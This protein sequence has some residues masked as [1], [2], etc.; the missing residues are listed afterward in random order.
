MAVYQK[1]QFHNNPKMQPISFLVP[2]FSKC[3]TTTL[4]SLLDQH[5]D[6]Y[7]PPL[8]EPNFFCDDDYAERWQDYINLFAGSGKAR[9]LG[10]GSTFYTTLKSEIAVRERILQHYPDIKLIFI[11]RDPI[12]RIESSFR[13]YHHSGPRFGFDTPFT[14]EETLQQFPEIISDTQYWSRLQ[15]YRNYFPEQNIHILFLEDLKS[16]TSQEMEKC[17]RFLG[18]DPGFEVQDQSRQLNAG[19]SKLYDSRLLRKIR[20]TQITGIP[21]SKVPIDTQDRILT[22][23]KLRRKFTEP[24]SWKPETT[25]FLL[26]KLEDEMSNF[27]A[28]TDKPANYWPRYSSLL[29][30]SHVGAPTSGQPT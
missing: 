19:S 8:K 7:I 2:G 29:Q 30:D 22:K 26:S 20:N 6:I 3:G 15:N 10:E 23:L 4:C 18:V 11:A 21:L 9:V 16:Q 12:N 5:P 14:L 1:C 13:E 28:H 27:L 17:F 24:V 25:Q